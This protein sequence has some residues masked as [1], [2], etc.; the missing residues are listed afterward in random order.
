M[1]PVSITRKNRLTDPHTDTGLAAA[2]ENESGSRQ[3][4]MIWF[5]TI[6]LLLPVP[7]TEKSK[8]H[9]GFGLQGSEA[10]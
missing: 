8:Y 1:M 3:V 6:V 9:R 4:R 2:K 10:F 7:K 5:L